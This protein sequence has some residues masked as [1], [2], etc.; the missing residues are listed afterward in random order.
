MKP[1]SSQVRSALVSFAVIAISLGS[2]SVWAHHSATMFE[3][4]K[5]LSFEGVVKQ[6]E[7][8]N[9][10]SWLQV[11]TV[12]GNGAQDEWSLEMGPLVGLSRAGWKP[13]MLRPGDKVKVSLHPLKNGSYGGRLISVTLSDGRVMNGQGGAAAPPPTG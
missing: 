9:P 5:V 4:K 2:A 11:V 8:S 7:W 6:F 13:R 3:P 1:N 10:H 12:D